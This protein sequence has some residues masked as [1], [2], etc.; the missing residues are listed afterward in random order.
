MA[1]APMTRSSA[2]QHF[3]ALRT[4]RRCF[5]FGPVKWQV[6]LREHG[7]RARRHPPSDIEADQASEAILPLSDKQ[8]APSEPAWNATTVFLV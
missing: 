1:V 6:G 7:A 4:S 5:G 2:G 3:G 8:H